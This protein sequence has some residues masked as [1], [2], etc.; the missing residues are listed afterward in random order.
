MGLFRRKGWYYALWYDEEGERKREALNTKDKRQAEEAWARIIEAQ[1]VR[2]LRG[3]DPERYTAEQSFASLLE[4]YLDDLKRQGRSEEHRERRRKQLELIREEVGAITIKNFTTRR[5]RGAL[6]RTSQLSARTQND[7]RA[8][9]HAFFEWL[10]RSG[11]WNRNPVKP[12]A[13]VRELDEP[14]RRALMPDE[15]RAL[16]E[17]APRH[18]AILYWIVGNLGLRRSESFALTR[19]QFDIKAARVRLRAAGTKAKRWA[20]LPL[21]PSVAE[22]VEDWDADPLIVETGRTRP[23]KK[24]PERSKKDK[25]T[26]WTRK[27]N[28]RAAWLPEP[29]NM[30]TWYSDLAEAGI[31]KE[32]NGEKLVFHSL[33]ATFITNLWRAGMTAAEVCRYGR[34]ADVKTALR[35]YTKLGMS[36]DQLYRERFEEFMAGGADADR[37]VG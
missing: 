19:E 13:V 28:T 6:T 24:H 32:V 35:Y 34:L 17:A 5:I 3:E 12:I 36:D 20:S 16:C 8:A 27:R 14:K 33:R 18:R 23:A 25:K 9:I 37:K 11:W 1:R 31:E 7:Y 29:P 30:K 22:R 2:R 4:E 15:L 26:R 10:V 21:I